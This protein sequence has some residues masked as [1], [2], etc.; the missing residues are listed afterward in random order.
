MATRSRPARPF[1]VVLGLASLVA[2]C[3][4][5]TPQDL[6]V[7]KVYIKDYSLRVR[8]EASTEAGVE[9]MSKALPQIQRFG[10]VGVFALQGFTV[11]ADP[12][13]AFATSNNVDLASQQTVTEQRQ[14]VDDNGAATK[15]ETVLRKPLFMIERLNVTYQVPEYEIP[16][17]TIELNVP[18]KSN[19]FTT[20]P[21]DIAIVKATRTTNGASP[22]PAIS[23]DAINANFIGQVTITAD[24]RDLDPL[25]N[26]R[27]FSVS[28]SIPF[29][30]TQGN[31]LLSNAIA[32]ATDN[33]V[34]ISRASGQGLPAFGNVIPSTGAQSL[35][36][37]TPAGSTTPAPSPTATTSSG[38][39]AVPLDTPTP[40]PTATPSAAASP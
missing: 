39:V 32:R 20:D 12:V 9:A 10:N 2:A 7:P 23:F 24:L 37:P 1:V 22:T 3:A 16:S 36:T 31:I 4:Q 28:R 29:M 21:L 27:T 6:Q 30:Y 17:R 26:Q 19:A 40:A 38:S 35:A 11:V 5:L 13:L 8:G 18:M 14:T 34:P 25:S 15:D 33:N